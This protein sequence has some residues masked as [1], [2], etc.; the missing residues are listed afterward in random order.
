MSTTTPCR[1]CDQRGTK[2]NPTGLVGRKGGGNWRRAPRF[3]DTT[4]CARCAA[5]LMTRVT[6]GHLTQ[7]RWSIAGLRRMAALLPDPAAE[8]ETASKE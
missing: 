3:Y 2:E 8:P 1:R 6:R 4:I 5:E 7:D